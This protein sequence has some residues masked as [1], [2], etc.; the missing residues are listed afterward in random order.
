M[1]GADFVIK[2]LIAEGVDT[3][4][5]YPG[6]ASIPFH[7]RLIDYPQ[8]KHLMPRNEQGASLA[9]DAYFRMTGRPGVCLST[10]GPGA[11]NLITGIANAYMD[12]V[13]MIVLT[14]QVPTT[15]I[16]SDAFQEIDITGMTLPIVKHSYVVTDAKDIPRII[17]EAFYIASTGR[18]GPVHIDLPKDVLSAVVGDFIYPNSV[19]I[20]GYRIKKEVSKD[21]LGDLINLIKESSNPIVIAGH[22]LVL[23]E[24]SNEFKA[25]IEKTNL[26]VVSTLLGLGALE[27]KHSQ[28]LGML[29][30]HGLSHANFAVHYADLI[31]SMGSRFDD[32]ITGKLS[33]FSS[34]AKIVHLDIDPAEIN[35]N[36][37]IDLPLVG[38]CKQV[39]NQLLNVLKEEDFNF[40]YEAWWKKIE[41]WEKE[42]KEKTQK[43]LSKSSNALTAKDVIHAIYEETD[44]EAVIV[45]DVGQHQM[46]IAQHYP[47]QKP[48]KI[49]TS[50]G[51]GTMGYSLPAAIGAKVA[52]PKA[53]IW[54]VMGDGGFQMNIQELGMIM[55]YDI[56]IKIIVLNNSFLGM[57]R[58]WQELF[59]DKNYAST[60]MINPNFT[61]IVDAYNIETHKVETNEAMIAMIKQIKN[62]DKAV[63]V[64]CLIEKEESVFP[65]VPPG[66]SLAETMIT[67]D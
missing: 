55:E 61:K 22:G 33:E 66:K 53:D 30:M 51:L 43:F 1:V 25:F 39:L 60:E 52:D 4:F 42:S 24:A 13:G 20:P 5:G 50:G 11:T 47:C 56:P 21:E 32:R 7:D 38:D 57:V 28:S 40:K 10:S 27:Q 12:S 45:S 34:N 14:C 6:G 65:M 31:I 26:P 49:L 18:K 48:N 17:K 23:S 58:Q 3:I 9:A 63:F 37:K 46:W 67:Q 36:L 64:E 59:H 41:N 35:K 29:G 16:G 15:V 44:G 19:N 62:Y 8:M 54:A 2:S